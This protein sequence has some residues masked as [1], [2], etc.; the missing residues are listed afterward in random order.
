VKSV[1][2]DA[3]GRM[4]VETQP[5]QFPGHDQ[6]GIE[7][8]EGTLEI[9]K[10]YSE[11]RQDFDIDVA[12]HS[13]DT[14]KMKVNQFHYIDVDHVTL[15]SEQDDNTIILKV[16]DG[17]MYPNLDVM[18]NVIVVDPTN[19]VF[20]DGKCYTVA[21]YTGSIDLVTDSADTIH[22]KLIVSAAAS[23]CST[24]TLNFIDEANNHLSIAIQL[25]LPDLSAYMFDIYMK[26]VGE[27]A[28][29]YT[30]CRIYDYPVS[31]RSTVN[32]GASYS[33]VGRVI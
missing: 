10:S 31:N 5:I 9:Q 23:T 28:S 12:D 22:C 2:Q 18:Q 7:S 3:N 1:T 33:L 16:K 4:Q 6:V 24:V 29:A 17:S 30:I 32:D 20:E 26:K 8:P 27:D 15:E 14:D 25:D 11:G 13:L 21:N 19:I